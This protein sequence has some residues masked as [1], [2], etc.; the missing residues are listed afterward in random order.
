M[1]FYCEQLDLELVGSQYDEGR[2]VATFNPWIGYGEALHRVREYGCAPQVLT[3]GVLVC[4]AIMFN[5]C[6]VFTTTI[7]F[8][9]CQQFE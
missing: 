4:V 8:H 9:D 6:S 7:V 5:V 3:L 1:L 2:K